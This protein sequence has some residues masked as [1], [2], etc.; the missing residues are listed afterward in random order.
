MTKII[1]HQGKLITSIEDWAEFYAAGNKAKHW[2]PARSAY[3]IADYVLNRNGLKSIAYRVSDVIDDVIEFDKVTPELEVKFDRYG[4]GR[5]H[6]LGIFGKTGSGKSLF[7]GVEAKVDESFN[8]SIAEVYLQAISRRIGGDRTKVPER[9]EKLLRDHF[10]KPEKDVFDLRY[11]LLYTTAGT[12]ATK[13]DISLMY[14]IV[15][16]TE[17]YDELKGL[18]NQ[19]DYIAFLNASR[20]EELECSRPDS[21]VHKIKVFRKSLYSI[22]EQIVLKD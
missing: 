20:S 12:L 4:Q 19:K 10:R 13:Q 6:D 1:N 2:K 18:E 5:V 17:L 3:S 15:F 14:F 9:I 22:Y 11:Q 16:K 21:M 8:R 7:V